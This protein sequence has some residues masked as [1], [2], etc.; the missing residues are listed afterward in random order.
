MNTTEKPFFSVVIPTYERPDGLRKCLKSLRQENQKFSPVY[1]IIVTDD[2]KSDRCCRLVAEEF[3]SV[4]WG[5]GKKNGPAGNRNAGV[6]RAKGKWIVFLDDDCIAEPG[7]LSAF[8]KEIKDDPKLKVLEGRIFPDRPKKTWAEGCPANETGEMFWTSNLCINKSTFEDLGGLDERF[9]VAFED[10]D[11]AYRFKSAK[12][13]TKFVY[14]AAVCHPWRTLNKEGNNWKP[15]GYEWNELNLFLKKHPNATEHKS[16][17]IYLRHMLRMLTRDIATCVIQ[18][19]GRGIG[20]WFRQ[21]LTT[22]YV[23]VK[24]LKPISHYK[25]FILRKTPR[26]YSFFASFQKNPNYEKNLYL[27]EI[28]TEDVVIDLGAN[29][30]I[31]SELFGILVNSTG[32]VHCFEPV[33]LNYQ[34]L[35]QNTS[36]LPWV[37]CYPFAVGDKNESREMSF[38]ESDLQKATL[39]TKQISANA[40]VIK[41]KVV[42]LDDFFSKEGL[43]RIDFIKC[44]VEGFELN[45]LYGM[46]RILKEFKPKLSIEI[47]LPMDK[48]ID[49]FNFL[50]ICGYSCFKKIES[51]YPQ[52]LPERE[53][54]DDEY[55]YLYAN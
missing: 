33:P 32:N 22:A 20:I 53:V 47:T 21:L 1:E 25:Q 15:I 16:P 36:H 46:E 50:C 14:D 52:I 48:R 17:S 40:K 24:L 34:I 7:Y 42:K 51:G 3:P 45:A 4:F 43:E 19:K 18:F 8:A 44:D 28:K 35:E 2:S 13:K 31:F 11:L 23:M 38:S 12:V 41:V 29:I 5:E 27:K 55:F 49:L 54:P 39:S 30:G 26:I 37:F 9:A 6:A 10:V